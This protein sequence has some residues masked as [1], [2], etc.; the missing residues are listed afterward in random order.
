MKRQQFIQAKEEEIIHEFVKLYGEDQRE[1]LEKNMREVIFLFPDSQVE[2]KEKAYMSYDL[3][4][5]VRDVPVEITMEDV[6][7]KPKDHKKLTDL[8]EDL[9]FFSFL[10][11]PSRTCIISN[12]N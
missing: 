8:Y 12:S 2:D 3:A 6:R 4:T 5:I 7:I 9:E 11:S 1:R 10:K